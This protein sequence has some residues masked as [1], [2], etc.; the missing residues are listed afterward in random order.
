MNHSADTPVS[1]TS[2]RASRS[3]DIRRRETRYLMSMGIRTL[4]FVGAFV[5]GGVLRW[6]LVAAAVILPYVAVVI[7]NATDR[8]V[9][10]G[11]ASFMPQDQPMLEAGPSADRPETGEGRA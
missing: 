1:I 5:A 7:A 6:V 11:P 8:R 9:S 10:A 2:A 3:A 4:C